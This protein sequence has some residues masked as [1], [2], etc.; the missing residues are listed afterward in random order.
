MSVAVQVPW[1][2]LRAEQQEKI[3]TTLAAQLPKEEPEQWWGRMTPEHQQEW[4]LNDE[5]IVTETWSE[6]AQ[7]VA[8]MADPETGEAFAALNHCEVSQTELEADDCTQTSAQQ[9]GRQVRLTPAS[10]IAPRPVRWLWDSRVALGS[11]CL[12]AGREGVGKSSIGYTLAAQIT[13][14]TL[15]GIYLG[16]PKAVIFAATE[17]SWAYTIVP[18]LMAAGADLDKV[19]KAD[20]MA[21]DGFDEDLVLPADLHELEAAATEVDAALVLLDPLISRLAARLDS[22]KDAEVR[23]AL[24]PLTSLADRTGITV[25]GII[26]VN[27]SSSGDALNMVMGSR[28]FSAVARSVLF[29]MEGPDDVSVKLLGQPKNNLGPGGLPTL[30]YRIVG[31]RVADTGEGEVWTGKVEWIGESDLSIA[32]ALIASRD[33][34]GASSAL[35][36]ASDWLDDYLTG[37][38]G[39]AP[40]LEIKKA[41]RAV[42]H[43]YRTLDRARN[44][45][46]VTSESQEFPRV[47][48]WVMPPSELDQ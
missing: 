28:A 1:D 35:R 45:L 19:F 22:H 33:Q 14:G 31:E 4:L 27:K 16:A 2:D 6:D 30:T 36:E 11:L 42:G 40:S 39:A 37:V 25:L 13:K 21:F 29:A 32:D 12:L 34:S 23:R 44:H 10:E 47:T 18:R 26:H 9:S 48:R 24:E 7:R 41:G 38:G 20:V 17:D 8:R 43:S 3:G 15:P 46:G 5:R